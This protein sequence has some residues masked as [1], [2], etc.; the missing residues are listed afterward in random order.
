MRTITIISAVLITVP[1]YK[2][3]GEEPGVFVILSVVGGLVWS[4]VCDI[5]E[6]VER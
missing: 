1:L 3:V 6:W 5:I 2:L 4:M